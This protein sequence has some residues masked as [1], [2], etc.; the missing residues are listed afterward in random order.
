M[1]GSHSG[2]IRNTR[3]KVIRNDADD[4]FQL[5]SEFTTYDIVDEIMKVEDENIEM[6]YNEF[7]IQIS[8]IV[9]LTLTNLQKKT[10]PIRMPTTKSGDHSA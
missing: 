1:R 2:G 4:G 3:E 10:R 9:S 8:V 7:T 5:G 6:V